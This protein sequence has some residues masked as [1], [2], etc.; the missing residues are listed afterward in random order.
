[1][2]PLTAPTGVD[3]LINVTTAA[4]KKGFTI[5]STLSSTL[6]WPWQITKAITAW[7]V[8]TIW[9]VFSL[10]AISPAKEIFNFVTAPFSF[11][12]NILVEL[13]PLLVFLLY[14]V[15]AGLIAGAIIAVITELVMALTTAILP[16]RDTAPPS[17]APKAIEQGKQQGDLAITSRSTSSISSLSL[18]SDD[19]PW[20]TATSV[21]PKTQFLV[22]ASTCGIKQRP[23]KPPLQGLLTETIHEESSS[24]LPSPSTSESS[25]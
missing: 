14:A 21:S 8:R 23:Q 2:D 20:A 13:E 3:A 11:V 4:T 6:F 12:I 10:F 19:D 18:E 15:A 1:M 7:A 22:P 17:N 24:N 25:A 16:V 5:Y 9:S